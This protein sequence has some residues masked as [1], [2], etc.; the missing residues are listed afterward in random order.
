[1]E[2]PN[3]YKKTLFIMVVVFLGIV[4]LFF[5]AKIVYEVKDMFVNYDM[6]DITLSGHGEVSAVPDIANVSFTISKEAK[7]VKE[8]QTL[9][10]EIEKK[11]I[12]FLKESKILEK[13]IKT[14]NASFYPK[15]QYK[16]QYCNQYICPEGKREIIGYVASESITVK[17]RN[18][19]DA[20]KIIE[21]LGALG[22]SELNGPNFAIDDEE[23]LKEEA[24]KE[25]IENA[26]EKAKILAENLGVKLGKILYFSDDSGNEYGDERAYKTMVTASA[27]GSSVSAE[28]PTGESLITSDVSIT[29]EIK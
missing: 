10:A 24:Q 28:M 17:I 6:S 14:E 4:S 15:Y 9:V 29:Y 3:T 27:F 25:A 18:V 20:G 23:K 2:I 22:V 5:V 16:T 21:G 11:S 19:D 26:K 12:D 7:T 8:A 13:D 1:M